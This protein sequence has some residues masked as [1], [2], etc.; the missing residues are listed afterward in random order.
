MTRI[1]V[2]RAAAA[3]ACVA[4]VVAVLPSSA[5]A[6]APVLNCAGTVCT[7]TFTY[8]GGVQT[9]VVPIG[10]TQA[11]FDV[12]GAAGGAEG[13]SGQPVG[14]L[15]GQ[16][17]GTLGVIPGNTYFVYVGGVGTNGNATGTGSHEPRGWIQRWRR[18]R[19]A[20]IG[21]IRSQW[22]WSVG[23]PPR[24]DRTVVPSARGRRRRW[25]ELQ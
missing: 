21:R 11:N 23:H 14:G 7:D 5:F 9:W 17:E 6:T 8:T 22:R 15:G 18:R 2:G 1:T 25:F 16:V 19:S 10:V 24:W 3:A 13:T 20:G 12:D 4:G